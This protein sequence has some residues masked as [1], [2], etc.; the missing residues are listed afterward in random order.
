[1]GKSLKSG[2]YSII[3]IFAIASFG[4][5]LKVGPGGPHT[6]SKAMA[7]VKKGDTVIVEK[8]KYRES[9]ALNPG[10]TIISEKTFG[11]EIIGGNAKKA[12]SLSSDCTIRGFKVTGAMIGIYSAGK[13]NE[14]VEC[15]ITANSQSGIMCVGNLPKIYNNIIAYNK[16]SGI[17]GW[18]VRSTIFSINHNTI[19]YNGNHAVS[20]GGNSS[21]ILE[22][23]I[24]AFN[25][26][27]GL[28]TEPQVKVTMK[29]NCF[30]GNTEVFESFPSDN[31]SFDPQFKAPRKMD[32]SLSKDS[33]CR[34][35]GTDNEDIGARVND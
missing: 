4:T 20:L 33:R 14:I 13:S 7:K 32:F 8:G 11:A 1:M 34:N 31:F 29:K 9:I 30:F 12:V 5:T 19:A 21:I 35:M 23:N 10:V 3:F 18:D 6:I 26:K 24:L 17:Q 27:M 28:K 15:K 22:N 25:E 2:G 16:G